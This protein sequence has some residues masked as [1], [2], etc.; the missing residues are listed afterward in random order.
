[1][2]NFLLVFNTISNTNIVIDLFCIIHGISV[3]ICL[4]LYHTVNLVKCYINNIDLFAYMHIRQHKLHAHEYF[5]VC[6]GSSFN[7]SKVVDNFYGGMI[8]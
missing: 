3:F 7:I 4:D 2:L 6:R 1:M 5:F 8:S